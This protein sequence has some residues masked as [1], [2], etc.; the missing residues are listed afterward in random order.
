MLTR[1]GVQGVRSLLIR[2]SATFQWRR[3]DDEE[4]AAHGTVRGLLHFALDLS[5]NAVAREAIG[6]VLPAW[7]GYRASQRAK[8]TSECIK[9]N[10]PYGTTAATWHDPSLAEGM[11]YRTRDPPSSAR[12]RRCPCHTGR[13]SAF[14]DA[15][16]CC[17]IETSGNFPFVIIDLPQA[18]SSAATTRGGSSTGTFVA[19]G[20]SFMPT[21]TRTCSPVM[22]LAVVLKASY[23]HLLRLF[24]ELEAL[25]LDHV[26]H[27]RG[28]RA[29]HPPQRTD[30]TET[31]ARDNG[32]GQVLCLC[33]VLG[34][35]RRCAIL[36]KDDQLR[37]AAAEHD[38]HAVLEARTG[39]QLVLAVAHGLEQRESAGTGG[40]RADGHVADVRVRGGVDA[41]ERVARLVV[42]DDALGEVVA[43]VFVLAEAD[44]DLLKGEAEVLVVDRGRVAARGEH[45]A[46]VHEVL[47]LG[48]GE[49]HGAGGPV[50]EADAFVEG[51]AASVHAQDLLPAHL[52][53]H[54]DANLAIEAAGTQ[55]RRVEDVLAV[56]GGEHEDALGALEAVHLGEDLVQGLLTLVVAVADA[57]ATA[58]AH[59]V[60]LVDENHA[61]GV[62]ARLLEELAHAGGTEADEHL[63]ELGSGDAEELRVGLAGHGTRQEG[64][65]RTGRALEEAPAGQLRAEARVLG[66]VLEEVHDLHEL[67]LGFLAAGDVREAGVRALLDLVGVPVAHHAERATAHGAGEAPAALPPTEERRDDERQAEEQEE[68]EDVRADHVEDAGL[69]ALHEDV[70]ILLHQAL[71]RLAVLSAEERRRQRWP[72]GAMRGATRGGPSFVPGTTS[73]PG[74]GRHPSRSR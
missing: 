18:D 71:H 9:R 60:D 73:S 13:S 17:R 56:G 74:G 61:G 39:R 16:L 48:A 65:S 40:R 21:C 63:H 20:A 37:R 23:C 43:A 24:Y 25:L 62:L 32:L 33:Q 66:R 12:P 14:A 55:Q 54:V 59:G 51:T 72:R 52:V 6:F 42:G 5:C 45:G 58:A 34:R 29:I 35:T 49:A 53:G 10:N 38:H 64:L 69:V 67:A 41:R 27:G 11:T 47:Q 3:P 57:A 44:H 2:G 26:R 31:P 68:R 1:G 8:L 50:I 4:S 36:P 19:S 70:D 28:L 7:L 30:V 15:V 46:F 22:L